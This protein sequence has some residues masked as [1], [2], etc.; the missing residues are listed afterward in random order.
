MR[1]TS[2]FCTPDS[3]YRHTLRQYRPRRTERV[4]CYGHPV[5]VASTVE[6]TLAL[7]VPQHAR[8]SPFRKIKTTL[9]R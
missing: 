6:V 4:G 9:Y 3:W 7:L 1:G 2:T 5:A 8:V